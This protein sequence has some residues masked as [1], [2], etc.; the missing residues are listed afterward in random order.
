[1]AVWGLVAEGDYD[2]R[3]LQV[4]IRRLL[5]HNL[6]I[7]ARSCRGDAKVLELSPTFLR[8]ISL[9]AP[10][11]KALVV[12]D[13]GTSR[14]WTLAKLKREME[15]RVPEGSFPFPIK[16]AV[17]VKE[18]EA[19]FLADERTLSQM[20]GATVA[21]QKSPEKIHHPKNDAE[22]HSFS[23][24]AHGPLLTGH[25]GIVSPRIKSATGG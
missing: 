14:Q 9:E 16:C 4:L 10:I 17:A 2:V 18:I 25:C 24:V 8:E 12:R 3:V 13:L 22:G 11:D 5:G 23:G 6:E 20:T 7:V 21:T 15:R 19:W 1:M